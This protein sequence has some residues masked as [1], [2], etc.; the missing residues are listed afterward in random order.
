MLVGGQS[1]KRQW[2]KL[3]EVNWYPARPAEG[4]CSHMIKTECVPLG[5][6]INVSA[7]HPVSG[8]NV[9]WLKGS[10]P[11][12]L[13]AITQFDDYCLSYRIEDFS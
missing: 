4:L 3:T 5:E 10:L 9:V 2:F 11:L 8:T 1:P 13:R 6:P 12:I 7:V